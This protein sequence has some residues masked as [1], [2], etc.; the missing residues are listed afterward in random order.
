MIQTLHDCVVKQIAEGCEQ[1]ILK[2]INMSS[3]LCDRLTGE[4]SLSM[5]VQCHTGIQDC[6][7]IDSK[8]QVSKSLSILQKSPHQWLFNLGHFENVFKKES[9][10]SFTDLQRA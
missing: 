3:H 5:N 2:L 7:G 9:L 6:Y 10:G 1:D 8:L 4:A